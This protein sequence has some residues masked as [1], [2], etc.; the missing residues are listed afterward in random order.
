MSTLK[1][2]RCG[3]GLVRSVALVSC[4]MVLLVLV[5]HPAAVQAQEGAEGPAA[6]GPEPE[7]PEPA[8]A[9]PE[10][11]PETPP[12]TGGYRQ[13]P[14]DE[15]QRRR[16]FDITKMLRNGKFEP[17]EQEIFD[18]YYKTY[19]LPRWTQQA[20]Y[21][22]LPGCRKDLGNELKIG[23][24]GA[25]HDRLVVLAMEFFPSVAK[26]D[27]YPAVVRFNAMLMLG[28]L[29]TRDS[30]VS[31]QLPVPLPDAVPVLLETL[32]DAQQID[33][34]RVAA[35]VGIGRHAS[36]GIAD[37]QVLNTQVLPSMVQLAKTKVAPGRSAEGHAWVRCLAI[38]VLA[39]LGMVG[40]Q[41]A[42][43][44]ALAEIAAEEEAA[45]S[46]RAAAAQALGA[47]NYTGATGLNP[48]EIA[49][50][51]G[52]LAADACRQELE[53]HWQDNVPV[54]RQRLKSQLNA[55]ASGLSGTG[56]VGTGVAGIPAPAPQTA[57]V[58]DVVAQLQSL[59]DVLDVSV[60]ELESDIVSTRT[61]VPTVVERGSA[62]Y[63]SLIENA[64]ARRIAAAQDKLTEFL[65]KGPQAT[66]TTP[67]PAAGGGR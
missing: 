42:V 51:L 34:V 57:F 62:E 60:R 1:D 43:A 9:E 24:T 65:N 47:L 12:A 27:S 26:A 35:L 4:V 18:T 23:K 61:F 48:S 21:N 53:R 59:Y 16:R 28:D 30:S 38:D 49:S 25:P 10:A 56:G 14:V 45:P 19:A 37:P 20:N 2:P 13:L 7:G 11:A 55:V 44:K 8:P 5:G 54:S 3:F 67:P 58:A 63:D 41:A 33:A 52:R 32:G 31:S 6:A 39:K 36:L 15:E 50:V 66:G 46:V 64:L 17:G 40:P 29:N 22:S